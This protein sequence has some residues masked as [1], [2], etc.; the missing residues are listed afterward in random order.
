VTRD[1]TP[2]TVDSAAPPHLAW[3]DALGVAIEPSPEAWSAAFA[4]LYG[5]GE[6]YVRGLDALA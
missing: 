3:V 5:K 6:E 4:Y 1:D 2:A